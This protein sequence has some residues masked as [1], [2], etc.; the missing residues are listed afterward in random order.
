MYRN[1]EYQGDIG[2]EPRASKYIAKLEGRS[3]WA[4]GDYMNLCEE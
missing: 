1:H 2:K 4:V 3:P